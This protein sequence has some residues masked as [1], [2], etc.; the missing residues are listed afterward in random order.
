MPDVSQRA[1]S[2]RP[3][4]VMDVVARAKELEAQGRDIVR[5]EIGDPDFPTPGV[6]VKAAEAAMDAGETGY[7]QSLGL[8]DLRDAIAAHMHDIYGAVVDAGDIVVTQGTSPAMLLLFGSLLDPADEVIMADP[9]YPAYPNYV[10]FL[11]GV[12]VPVRVR[13]EDGFRFR[14]DDVEAAITSR[15]KAVMVNSPSNPT[16]GV[17][18][19]EDL[20][21][22]AALADR[23]GL[24]L[25]SDEIYHGLQFEGRS[26]TVLEF[27]DRAFVLNGF[28]KAYAMT[29]WR[30]GY[31]IAPR[32]FVRPAEKIQQ[33]FFLC[34]NHFV[35][36]AGTTALL[37]AGEDVARMRAVY[38]ERRRYLVPAL[39]EIGLGVATEPLG[40][41][42]VFADARA[43][44]ADSVAL[45]G[46][47][48]EEA[49]VAVAPGADFGP[50]G[51]GFLRFSYATSLERLH[52][53]VARLGQWADTTGTTLD[54]R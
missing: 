20:A 45:A 27:T 5:L 46:R 22:L 7:T 51:E 37:H 54:C 2:I 47:L 50:G 23:Y 35:Q 36:V 28:S 8:P 17:L 31:M 10:A 48:L 49:G 12:P 19:G 14:I 18:S 13:A 38:D 9:C 53:G 6:I 40:A 39:R 43:W 29:G 3:F 34:A 21:A 32:Q 30:L 33:N 15:T 11:G 4:V 42:Y 52:E 24:W 25:V 16:G 44:G 26:H 41:F 1:E